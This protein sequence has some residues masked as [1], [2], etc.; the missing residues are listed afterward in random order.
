MNRFAHLQLSNDAAGLR[1][2]AVLVAVL[3]LM[4]LALSG[5][6]TLPTVPQAAAGAGTVTDTAASV[7]GD[8]LAD[9]SDYAAPTPEPTPTG[10]PEKSYVRVSTAGSRAN[11]RNAPSLDSQIVG[12]GNPGDL[13]EVVGRSEDG[14]W[15][16]IC[17]VAG[18]DDENIEAWVAA[19]VVAVEGDPGDAPVVAGAS[20]PVLPTDLE[21]TWEVDW[22]CGS[23]RC[24]V[25]DCK[26]TVTAK[27]NEQST[28]QLLAIDH[29]VEWDDTCFSTDSW[30]F[31][32]N[33]FNGTER[34]GDFADNF[35]YSYWLGSEPGEMNAVYTYR[36]DEG[37]GVYCS[38]PYTV[39]IEEADG[40]ITVYEGSTCHD[41]A[42][43]MMVLMDY[44]KRW[45]YTGEFDGE[46]YNRAYFGDSETLVQRLIETNAN[47]DLMEKVR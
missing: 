1:R 15:W 12:K 27:A 37:V 16:N 9:V 4:A 6:Q 7:Q 45:L 32:V 13:F 2:A 31:E 10:Q 23:D 20:Q 38:G 34:T 22:K 29:T 40:W 28:N 26:A 46:S 36:D 47:L 5:C 17:C 39:E 19:S 8:W 11:I 3:A 41:V 21:A 43:G 42:T 14:E 18:A 44:T 33:P 24:A 30:S 35:L 25:P